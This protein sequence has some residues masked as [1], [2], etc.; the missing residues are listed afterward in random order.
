MATQKKSSADANL[1][2]LGIELPAAP[3]AAA[4]YTTFVRVGNVVYTS[5]HVSAKPDGARIVGKVGGALTV[6][7]AAEAARF[8]A[9]SL[10][11][12]LKANLDSLDKVK[13]IIKV[14]GMINAVPDF[15]DHSRVMNGCSDILVQVFGDAG[16]HV[17]TSVGM[18]SLPFNVALEIEIMAE[19]E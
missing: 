17:R 19:V 9:L 6:E 10:M 3:A 2:H 4:N 12:T 5:G 1:K 16:K 8:T 15:A 18:G 13:R 11:A 14:T 7:Q